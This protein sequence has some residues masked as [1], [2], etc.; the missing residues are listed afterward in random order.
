MSNNTVKADLA[1][2]IGCLLASVYTLQLK[3]HGFHWNVKGKDFYEFHEFFSEIQEDLYSSVDGLAEN[4]LKLGYDAPGS[5]SEMF[6]LSCIEDSAIHVGEPIDMTMQF[7]DGNE[8]VIEKIQYAT[9]LAEQC[10]EYGLVDFLGGREDMHKKWA[11]QGRAV[12]GLQS[13]KTLGK[14]TISFVEVVETLA[15][16]P[17][18]TGILVDI[19]EQLIPNAPCCANGCACTPGS[20]VCGSDCMCVCTT[21]M[22]IASATNNDEDRQ[23]D[24]RKIFF[25]KRVD[26]ALK[27]KV[28]AHNEKVPSS[29]K[30]SLQTVKAVYRRGSHEYVNSLGDTASRDAVAMARVNAFLRLLSSGSA[31]SITQSKDCDL[32]PAGHPK[33]ANAGLALTASVLA[34]SEMYI[35][36]KKESEY[37][38]TDDALIAM[39]EYSGIGY[40]AIPA[41]KAAWTRAVKENENPFERAKNLSTSLYN[42]K[43]ADLLPRRKVDL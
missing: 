16:V 42:S 43:D 19:V 14:D 6:A 13:S 40:E 5:L 26:D 3:V 22:L 10:R 36:I 25:S 21:Q 35:S 20:C 27:E 23:A 15:P 9:G 8:K 33:A 39:A 12:S 30:A 37:E 29:R 28:N 11:W 18:P 41:L 24:R 31:S 7:L 2:S 4:I 34:D 17:A 1:Q 32:L 38:S